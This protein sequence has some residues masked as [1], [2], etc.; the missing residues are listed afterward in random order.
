[1]ALFLDLKGT[2]LISFVLNLA[3]VRLKDSSGNLLIRNNADNA[4]AEVTASKV[5]VSGD[6]LVLN[7]DAAE[8]AS[9]WKLTLARPTGG[10]TGDLQLTLPSTAG[11]TGQA[12]V[13]D[14]TGGLSWASAGS[15]ADCI[16][17]DSTTIDYGD[18]SPVSMFTLPANAVLLK[19][20]MLID[21]P[22]NGTSPSLSI[23]ISGFAS[24]Y[25]PTTANNLKGTAGDSY[26]YHPVVT[27]DGGS[28]S[29]I[30]TFNSGSS[31][32]GSVRLLCYYTN[33]S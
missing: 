27:P 2:S 5:N 10:M 21:T 22:F 16:H 3:G 12:L 20:V 6:S 30:A 33:P 17:V 4:D 9:D 14:G 32:A 23:G 29:I 8:T 18:S 25:M 7:S 15:T 11:S 31:S 1:M 26:E 13:T 19:T 28:E 24:T